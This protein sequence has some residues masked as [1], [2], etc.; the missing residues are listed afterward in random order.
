M[1]CRCTICA[2]WLHSIQQAEQH[3]SIEHGIEEGSQ[4]K[5]YYVINSGELLPDDSRLHKGQLPIY[6]VEQYLLLHQLTQ[7][8]ETQT[9]KTKTQS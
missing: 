3:V 4:K 2:E 5:F 9:E 7:K 6:L 1:V 8:L